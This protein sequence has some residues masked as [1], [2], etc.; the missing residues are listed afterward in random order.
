MKLFKPPNYI[1]D[2]ATPPDTDYLWEHY[3]TTVVCRRARG[4]VCGKYTY[5]YN[6]ESK[7]YSIAL[8]LKYITYLQKS[9]L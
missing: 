8:I 3:T 9:Y 1:T 2:N 4:Q 5:T 7:S 6:N